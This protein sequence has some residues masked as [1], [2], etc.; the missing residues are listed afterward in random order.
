M[1]SA[2]II[3]LLFLLFFVVSALA[4]LSSNSSRNNN[5]RSDG[6]NDKSTAQSLQSSVQ[7]VVS[8][9]ENV[10]VTI[11]ATKD[12][13]VIRNCVT[14][15]GSRLFGI[16]FLDDIIQQRRCTFENREV[17]ISGGTGFAIDSQGIILTNRHVVD[18]VDAEYVVLFNNGN[19]EEVTQIYKDQ[20]T[21]IALLKINRQLDTSAKLGN[22]DELEVGQ[23]VV[24]IGNALGEFENSASFGIVSGLDRDIV[25]R[26][27]TGE[28]IQRLNNV[29]QTDAAVNLGNSGGPLINLNGEVVAVNAAR[30]QAENI[31]F[32][33]P[34]NDIKPFISRHVP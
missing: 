11:A 32:A 6:S 1:R 17:E 13:P 5:D 8:Q 28:N 26:D 23:F 19:E 4:G 27:I 7:N 15:R 24:A 25:A 30:A 3:I 34:I 12:V 22:S 2:R 21:D 31:G 16:S 33:I 18:D 20:N 10:V 14:E 29:I 9:Y